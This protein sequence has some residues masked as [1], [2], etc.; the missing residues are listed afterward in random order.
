MSLWKRSQM[1]EMKLKAFPTAG[2]CLAL[3]LAR[4]HWHTSLAA[5]LGIPLGRFGSQV[6]LV[7]LLT[8]KLLDEFLG[9]IKLDELTGDPVI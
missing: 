1:P 7:G 8:S 4:L 3:G 6:F 5:F 2:P 9:T